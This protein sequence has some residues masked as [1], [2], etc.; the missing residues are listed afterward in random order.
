MWWFQLFVVIFT[1]P[2]WGRFPFLLMFSNGF[3]NHKV[4]ENRRL[5][6]KALLEKGHEVGTLE[7]CESWLGIF[8]KEI[9][10]Q[11]WGS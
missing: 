11:F 5:Y 8:P 3:F 2:N 9:F 1:P 10:L 4:E 6:Y 7:P